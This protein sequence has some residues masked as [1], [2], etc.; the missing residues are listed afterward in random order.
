MRT[1]CNVRLAVLIL[2]SGL[3]AAAPAPAVPG[4]PSATWVG[5]LR[6]EGAALIP[7]SLHLNTVAPPFV[8]GTLTARAVFLAGCPF[9][10]SACPPWTGPVTGKFDAGS[11]VLSIQFPTKD[12]L[13][14]DVQCLSTIEVVL[15]FQP[16]GSMSGTG[17]THECSAPFEDSVNTWRLVPKP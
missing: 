2:A 7:V 13:S 10:T 1:F 15:N 16:D 12:L 11:Y 3:I 14:C 6:P 4:D 8:T 5:V 9:C 17:V